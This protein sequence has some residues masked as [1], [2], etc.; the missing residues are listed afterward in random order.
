MGALIYR[1]G[2]C[3]YVLIFVLSCSLPWRIFSLAQAAVWASHEGVLPCMSPVILLTISAS[4]QNWETFSAGDSCWENVNDCCP[5]PVAFSDNTQ[6]ITLETAVAMLNLHCSL[7]CVLL[8]L[9]CKLLPFQQRG[10]KKA[11]SSLWFRAHSAA[12][13]IM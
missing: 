4:G 13:Q 5:G 10:H 1:L 2:L 3:V 7:A 9:W 8:V 11:C 6:M 12:W